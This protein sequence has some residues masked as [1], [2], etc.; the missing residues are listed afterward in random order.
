MWGLSAAA[1]GEIVLGEG[2][3]IVTQNFELH[4]DGSAFVA[5]RAWFDPDDESRGR[6]LGEMSLVD[7]CIQLVDIALR[8]PAH[9]AGAW[10]AAT[11]RC[12]FMDSASEEPG[13]L[14]API[15]MPV[16][17]TARRCA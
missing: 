14:T 6:M 5:T 13:T 17:L 11:I 4:V 2:G 10:D 7:N 15:Q 1:W 8:W 9:Q 16:T 3:E 12:G